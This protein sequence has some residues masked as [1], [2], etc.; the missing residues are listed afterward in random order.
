MRIFI[1]LLLCI[2]SIVFIIMMIYVLQRVI[3]FGENNPKRT[4]ITSLIGIAAGIISTFCGIFSIVYHHGKGI[5]GL[6]AIAFCIIFAIK[7]EKIVKYFEEYFDKKH[8]ISVKSDDKIY[9]FSPETKENADFFDENS[10]FN[11]SFTDYDKK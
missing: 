7:L 8:Q 10:R 4:H 11:G 2:P 5:G 3:R 6:F 9:S 1:L